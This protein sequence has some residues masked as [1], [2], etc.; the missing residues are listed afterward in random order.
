MTLRL[1]VLGDS[2]AYGQGAARPEDTPARRLVD[3][4]GRRGTEAEARVFAVPGAR[5][6]ALAGQVQRA[7][8]WRPD[9]AV[10]VVGAN[11]LTHRVPVADV[12]R[13]LA[14]AVRRLRE[15]GVQVVVAP[16]PDLSVVPHVPAPLRAVVRAASAAVRARQVDVVVAE[17]GVV[18]DGDEGTARAFAADPSLFSGDDFHPSSAGYEVIADAL[19]PA[20]LDALARVH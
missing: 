2:I 10:V 20:V 18:A 19:L 11:D 8:G 12:G 5:S 14:D 16:A 3:A 7:I 9:V 15:A 4:L 17:G 6:A 1:A 13:H